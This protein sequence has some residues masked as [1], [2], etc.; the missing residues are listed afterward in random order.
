[1]FISVTNDVVCRVA[2]GKKYED[3]ESGRKFRDLL[4]ELMILLGSF[5]VGDFIPWLSWINVVNG[6]NA[7][8]ERV[9]REF[10][11][12]LEGIVDDRLHS[13]LIKSANV[14]ERDQDNKDFVNV[15]LDLQNGDELGFSIDKVS[16]KGLILVRFVSFSSVIRLILRKV[17]NYIKMKDTLTDT[18]HS[19]IH[20][21]FMPNL[22]N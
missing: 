22:T 17:N 18:T 2:F 21:I 8:V 4:G 1:M 19:L 13:R 7:K 16:I 6:F 15:L 3:G 5:N 14:D 9:A 20:K 11:K 10:D 12:F